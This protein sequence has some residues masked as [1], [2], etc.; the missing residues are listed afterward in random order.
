LRNSSGF[1]VPDRIKVVM[2]VPLQRQEWARAH[3]D[4]IAREILATRFELAEPA[5]GVE[6]DDGVQA[7]IAK[8]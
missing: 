2:S 8:V 4:L 1:D 5:D 3:Q 7:A 6:I